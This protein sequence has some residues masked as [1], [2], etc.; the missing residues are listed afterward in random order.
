MEFG[1]QLPHVNATLNA[2]SAG[3]LVAGFAFIR[4]K[5]PAAHAVCMIAAVVVS[6]LFLASYVYYHYQV[7][8]TPFTGT[9]PVRPVY[10]AVLLSHTLLAMLVALWLVPLTLYRA[11][12]R[13]FD[14]HKR[15]A[16]WTWP[17]W[18]YVSATGVLIYLML[19]HWYADA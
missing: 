18:L 17:V 9:G 11:A 6:V 19:Y 2:I 5:Q 10:F 14:R 15:V 13:Q 12:R 1:A 7:G 16:R 4:R 3:F 8:S